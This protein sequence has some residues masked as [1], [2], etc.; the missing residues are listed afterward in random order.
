MP[1]VY[2]GIYKIACTTNHKVYVGSSTDIRRRWNSHRGKLRRGTHENSYLQR[3]WK[4]YGESA[5]VFSVLEHTTALAL[6]ETVWI[7]RLRADH[8]RYGFNILQVAYAATGWHPTKQQ[9]QR[10]KRAVAK[11]WIITTPRGRQLTVKNLRTFCRKHKLQYAT[12]IRIAQGKL[13]QTAG[14]WTCRKSDMSEKEW[15]RLRTRIAPGRGWVCTSCEGMSFSVRS[16]QAF[17]RRHN[18]QVDCMR[19]VAFGSQ[20]EHR[21]WTCRVATTPLKEW[22][23][24]QPPRIRRGYYWDVTLPAGRHVRI[25]SLNQFCHEHN[26]DSSTMSKIARG[27][28]QQHH[29]YSCS[30]VT[31]DGYAT[32]ES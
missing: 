17:C 26:L 15:K 11:T 22:Q 30:R 19:R 8:R 24:T 16:L 32:L 7:T 10:F 2:S 12:M 20:R 9:L 21:G 27:T 18:L 5:F 25:R 4:K 1:E 6:Q 3:A 28:L 29:G 14:G 23:Q 13:L 31:E